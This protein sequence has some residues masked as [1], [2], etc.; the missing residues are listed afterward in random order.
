MTTDLHHLGGVLA[1]DGDAGEPSRVGRQ[2][3]LHGLALAPLSAAL[4][5]S[6]LAGRVGGF[7][8]L[9]AGRVGG[10]QPTAVLKPIIAQPAP[11]TVYSELV[12]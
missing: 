4:L 12:D 5:R 2:L 6:L 8:G 7:R 9:L 10:G 11:R 3:H 1:V